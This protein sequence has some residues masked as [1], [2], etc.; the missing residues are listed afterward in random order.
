MSLKDFF[1]SKEL[2][3]GTTGV[4]IEQVRNTGAKYRDYTET[5]RVTDTVTG[6]EYFIRSGEMGLGWCTYS[7]GGRSCGVKQYSVFSYEGRRRVLGLK[8][9]VFCIERHMAIQ[10][11]KV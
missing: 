7:R 1:L 2:E 6:I 8:E 9:S 11:K 3:F 10:R 4:T 5:Y